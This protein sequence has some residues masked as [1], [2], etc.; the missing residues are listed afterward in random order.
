MADSY[1]GYQNP[2]SVDKKLDS[3]SVTVGANTVER[4]RV[5]I[6]GTGATAIAPVDA[7][8]GLAVDP[9]TLPPGAASSANQSTEL[10]RLGDVTETAPATDTASSGLNGRLQR[11]AQRITS[12]IA[13]IPAALTG[14]GNFKVAVVESTVTQPV[15][16]ASLPLPSGASTSAKQDTQTTELTSIK[17][18]VETIDNF[19]SGSKGLVTED[20]SA[21]IKTAVEIID[22]FISGSR[23]LVTEDNS[24][25]IAASASVLDDWDESDRAKVNVI[26]GQ[27]GVD[28]N[29]GTK[30]AATI[31]VVLATDQ[32]Q[33]T[34]KL[35]VTPDANSAVNVA[36]INGVTPLM[37]A[38]NTG[39]GSPRVTIASDQ[40]TIPVKSNELP[41]A[42]ST[43]APTNAT[44]TAYETNRVVK[45]SAGVLFC[46]NGFNAKTT[47]QYIQLHNTAS[48]PADTAVPVIT[49]YVPPLSNFSIDFGGKFGRYFST[50]ITICNSSTGATKTIGSSDCWFDAQFI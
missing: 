10:T 5:Q 6:S 7:T 34:N 17:T 8:N 19:I 18:A 24:A 37:G 48:L 47:A 23:G 4:E 43:Y 1:I 29:S 32:P 41:D 22:N 26:V 38:G 3:E 21:S 12:L 2:S 11:I 28:G 20:N 14:S 40:V 49:I 45:A 33:L 13:L 42:T 30:S 36:Q 46:V 16:A 44:S 9:K 35:L 25:A 15:S 27:A 31:R 50:G 39:T